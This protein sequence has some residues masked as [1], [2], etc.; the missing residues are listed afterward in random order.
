VE[1]LV[2]NAGREELVAS[3]EER[4][5][6]RLVAGVRRL[7]AA[8]AAG[9]DAEVV[10]GRSRVDV[11]K[12]PLMGK[13]VA[14]EAVAVLRVA[15]LVWPL[16]PPEDSEPALA[17]AG[18]GDEAASAAKGLCTT[19]RRRLSVPRTLAWID[20]T[21]CSTS[22]SA[23]WGGA[24]PSPLA[25]LSVLPRVE[26]SPSILPRRADSPPVPVDPDEFVEEPARAPN[27]LESASEEEGCALGYPTAG[28][29][30]CFGASV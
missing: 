10:A 19:D 12:P 2:L 23:F 22:E 27:L 16:L 8:A 7:P 3:C 18:G 29:L 28:A 6:V 4:T 30:R 20:S 13:G 15:L 26:R 14:A 11:L 21:A 25:K 1:V 17:V 5:P 9:I 24:S